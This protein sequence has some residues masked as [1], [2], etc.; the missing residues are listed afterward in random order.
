MNTV[1]TNRR[2]AAPKVRADWRADLSASRDVSGRE[3]AGF[4]LVLGW[5]EKW[6]VAKG[7]EAGRPAAEC[8]WRECVRSKERAAWQLEQWAE[9]F[10]WYLRWVEWGCKL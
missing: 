8:F 1:D 4:E 10:R 9:A 3:K 5:F 6:R 7:V 2:A